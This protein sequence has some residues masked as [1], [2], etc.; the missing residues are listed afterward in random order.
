MSSKAS[1]KQNLCNRCPKGMR[2]RCCYYEASVRGVRV[3]TD[4]YCQYLDVAT[5][6]CTV[7]DR[8][9]QVKKD[10]LTIEA[11]I[12]EGTLPKNC[13]YVVNNVA[14]QARTDTRHYDD[15]HV[16]LK[17]GDESTTCPY[18][19]SDNTQ[20]NIIEGTRFCNTC[21]VNYGLGERARKLRQ[22]I[23]SNTCPVC[24]H[25]MKWAPDGYTCEGSTSASPCHECEEHDSPE[26]EP[27][28]IH[29][30]DCQGY[31]SWKKHNRDGKNE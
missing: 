13:P 17:P 20:E 14:Y 25:V 31:Q 9:H 23:V 24:G 7:Y 1:G 2:G 5:G 10:C 4:H 15:F 21:G 16:V 19:N 12:N 29:Q 6:K 30:D 28:C 8:K 11:M 26:D 27:E 3:E 18:C 22:G